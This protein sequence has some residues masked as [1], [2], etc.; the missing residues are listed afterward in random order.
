VDLGLAGAAVVVSG[1]SKGMGRAAAESI[2]AE[3]A[4]V[5][6][7]A[8]QPDALADTVAALRERGSPDAI[9]IRA[10]LTQ[11]DEVE[12]RSSSSVTASAR[13]MRSSTRPDRSRSA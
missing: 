8:R 7:L 3:G 9:G 4:R 13:C 10:D 2:A 12:A 6:V 1:G 5:A 11:T